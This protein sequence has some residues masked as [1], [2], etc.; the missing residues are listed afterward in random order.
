MGDE[1][2]DPGRRD[3]TVR[4]ERRDSPSPLRDRIHLD[5]VR[6]P[7]AVA[8]AG[9]AVGQTASGPYGVML[10]D[11]DGN[12]IDLVPGDALAGADTADWRVLF[13][14]M[15]GYRAATPTDAASF[16]VAVA[17]LSA[18]A[19]VPLLIDLRGE[20]VTI[21]SGK[22][23]WEDG[24]QPAGTTFSDLAGGVQAA[25]AD[26]DLVSHPDGLRFLQIGID[27]ADVPAVQTFWTAAL[28]YQRD[29]R[30]GVTD[31]YDPRWRSPVL[32]FQQI[33]P[34]DPPRRAQP[35]RIIVEISA[36]ADQVG[37]LVTAAVAAGGR[38]VGDPGRARHTVQDPEG[39]ELIRLNY[40]GTI[41]IACRPP[42]NE[43]VDRLLTT[44][45]TN[46]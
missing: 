1:L 24:F 9:A 14:A 28:G 31:I 23:R 43:L 15:A 44:V 35:P 34:D 3:P 4:I 42:A 41:M 32:I 45:G 8:A 21:E 37:P 46:W 5:V 6:P 25:A 36:P 29:S 39:N 17:T 12:E 40:P 30:P 10:A 2:T 26:R 22:D 16:A 20:S 27:A 18:D 7:E 11:P 33:E 13:S 19:G 38:V